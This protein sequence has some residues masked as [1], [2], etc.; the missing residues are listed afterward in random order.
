MTQN[1][2]IIVTVYLQHKTKGNH[3]CEI[4]KKIF[5]FLFILAAAAILTNTSEALGLRVVETINYFTDVM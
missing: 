5:I 3:M 2:D 1:N 4:F